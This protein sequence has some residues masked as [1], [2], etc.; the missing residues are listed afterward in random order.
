VESGL[1]LNNCNL[2]VDQLCG[3]ELLNQDN[4]NMM[5]IFM[6]LVELLRTLGFVP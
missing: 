6:V 4:N 1:L 5:D 3:L 2:L